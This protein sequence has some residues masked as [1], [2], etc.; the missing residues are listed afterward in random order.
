MTKRA[1]RAMFKAEKD[2]FYELVRKEDPHCLCR[3]ERK[4]L[5]IPE[6]W[7]TGKRGHFEE[8]LGWVTEMMWNAWERVLGGAKTRAVLLLSTRCYV[9]N[10]CTINICQRKE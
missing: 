5:P 6:R 4:C 1:S 7:G 3:L 9:Q 2:G 10:K 8:E